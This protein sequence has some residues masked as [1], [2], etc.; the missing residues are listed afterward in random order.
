V[1]DVI[2]LDTSVAVPLM[3]QTHRAHAAVGVQVDVVA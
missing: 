2:A 3:I 1:T